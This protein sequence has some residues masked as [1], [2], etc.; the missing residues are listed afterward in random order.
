MTLRAS[1]LVVELVLRPIQ[2]SI[3]VLDTDILRARKLPCLT[4]ILLSLLQL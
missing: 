3:Q 2:R 1:W 4:V